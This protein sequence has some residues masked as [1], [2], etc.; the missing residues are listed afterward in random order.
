[1]E[2]LYQKEQDGLIKKQKEDEIKMVTELSRLKI[3][4]AK[5][6]REQREGMKKTGLTQKDL[7]RISKE[8]IKGRIKRKQNKRQSGNN[9]L[10]ELIR[11]ELMF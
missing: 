3:K 1:M 10:K 8:E 11:K 2:R 9:E 7:D 6:K 5:I 4:L